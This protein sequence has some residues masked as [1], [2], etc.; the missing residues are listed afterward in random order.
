MSLFNVYPI[1]NITPIKALGA[2][3]WDDKNQEYLDFYGGHGVISVG[4]SH[5]NYV[6]AIQSQIE[7]SGFIPTPSKTH[8]RKPSQRN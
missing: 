3:V 6:K 8:C 4:H 5:P 7:K 2:K 1:Y